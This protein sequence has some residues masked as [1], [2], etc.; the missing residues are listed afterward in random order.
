M[1]IISATDGTVIDV[2]SVPDGVTIMVIPDDVDEPT[3]IFALS[4]LSAIALIE[5]V[6]TAIANHLIER[7]GPAP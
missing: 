1:S 2:L 7:G 4:L 6:A 5:A 3:T